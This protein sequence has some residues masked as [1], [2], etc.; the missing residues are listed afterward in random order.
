MANKREKRRQS[1]SAIPEPSQR[2]AP[3]F[4]LLTGEGDPANG[5]EPSQSDIIDQAIFG[6]YSGP[7]AKQ[8]EQENAQLR[9]EIAALEQRANKNLALLS[10]N[11]EVQIGV[12]RITPLGLQRDSDDDN[13]DDWA[14]VG[15]LLKLF[16]DALQLL[17]GDWIN[18]SDNFEYGI[19]YKK[20]SEQF[21]VDESTIRDWV[22][23]ARATE[24]SLRK[25]NLLYSHYKE[26]ARL[27]N[28]AQRRQ[29]AL[30]AGEEGWSVRKLR[31][32]VSALLNANKHP[33]KPSYVDVVHKHL[34]AIEREVPK[35]QRAQIAA[36]LRAAADRI[37]D[38]G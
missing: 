9:E 38:G 36:M 23:V 31:E 33:L 13:R 32:H 19:T 2:P 14:E 37:E 24:L 34:S 18:E 11:G 30:L 6:G 3:T 28:D 20:F 22:W 25:D 27:K 15:F 16:N 7:S 21:N 5:T 4:D 8:L 12:Y 1:N 35:D 17:I 29:V 26:L 10:G